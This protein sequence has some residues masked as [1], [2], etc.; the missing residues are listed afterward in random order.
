MLKR[1]LKIATL[2]LV[3]TGATA[4]TFGGWAVV[5]VEDVPEYL[6]AGAPAKITY[7]VRQHGMTLLDHLNGKLVATNGRAEVVARS[8]DLSNGRYAATL[9]LPTPGAWTIT[10]DGAW[11]VPYTVLRAMPVIPAGAT[12]PRSAVPAEHGRQLFAAKG[13][14]TCHVHGAVEGSGALKVGPDLTPKRYEAAFLARFLADPSIQRT[15]GMQNQMPNLMLKPAEIS[16]L[17]AFIN[18]DRQVSAR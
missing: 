2:M 10:V 11:G 18:A 8:T 4:F 3:A 17:V 6:T 12:P 13:C 9:T 15:P 14:V 1:P 5:T 16:A 7:T